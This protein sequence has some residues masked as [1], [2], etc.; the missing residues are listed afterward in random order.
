MLEKRE[1]A[2]VVVAQVQFS[3]VATFSA[4]E[5]NR[6][7]GYFCDETQHSQRPPP[8][9]PCRKLHDQNYKIQ[10]EKMQKTYRLL[11][12]LFSCFLFRR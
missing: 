8:L 1:N 3:F 7:L 11:P 6:V 2:S 5:P 9:S 12:F 10:R 4:D